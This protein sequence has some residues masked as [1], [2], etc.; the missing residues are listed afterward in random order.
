MNPQ[1]ELIT[2]IRSWYR[3]DQYQ[4]FKVADMREL[5]GWGKVETAELEAA[6][7]DLENRGEMVFL[8][9]RGWFATSREGWFVGTLSIARRGF[10]FVRALAVD[11]RGDVFIPIRRLR[12]GHHGDRVLVA[13]EKTRKGNPPLAGEGRSGKILEVI[14]RSPR[15][16][17]GY[18]Y[19]AEGGAGVV[20]P[21]RH[22]S[23]REVWIDPSFRSGVEDGDRVLAR[24]RSGAAI[25]GLPPGEVL[26]NWAPEG[27]WLA[28][29]Q[30]VCAEH[31]LREEFPAEVE[32]LAAAF[33][34]Q[35]SAE[36]LETRV[37]RR[38]LP[39]MTIDPVD[40][41]DFDDAIYALE[42]PE[43]GFRLG[44]A[45][46]DVSHFVSQ[47]DPI[48]QEALLRGTSVYIPGKTIPMLPERL[49]NGLCS[50]RPQEDRLAKIA[51]M[52][53]D[54]KGNFTDIQLEKSVIRSAHR[55]T[56]EGA[57]A[58]LEGNSTEEVSGVLKEQ[59]QVLN[60]LREILLKRRLRQG[61]LQ[62]EIEEMKLV[63]DDEGEVIDVISREHL[64]AHGLV[65]ECMLAANEAV[66]TFASQHQLPIL[67]RVHAPPDE[68][69]LDKFIKLCRVLV[70]EA[71][72]NSV[73]DL[74]KLIEVVTGSDLA[75]VV[76]FALLRSLTRA[77]YSPAKEVHFALQKQEYCHFTSPIRR[78]P[79]LQVHQILDRFF[80]TGG[81]GPKLSHEDVS[82]HELAENCST[83]ERA[84]E[85]AERDMSRLRAISW[86]RHRVGERFPGIVTSVRDQGFHVRLDGVLV[87]GFVHV[88][89]LRDDHYVF[90]ETHFALRGVNKGNMIRLGDPVEVELEGVD[91]LQRD[92]D[93]RYL[94]TRPGARRGRGTGGHAEPKGARSSKASKPRSQKSK[95]GGK[96]SAGRSRRRD[97][98]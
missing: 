18:F 45:I 69:E 20:E 34:E 5:P 22:E 56:Y 6:L 14:E 39:F 57:Q 28:D 80:S 19:E 8:F 33:P 63:L 60:Q 35:I 30:I 78:Y 61:A 76:F 71:P 54:S 44:V 68:S 64:E 11:P 3:S 37:D 2:A 87:D 50:L 42:L 36:E 55:F 24:L 81:E 75:P 65:E 82:L 9:A 26:C 16:F 21:A 86:L 92:I 73:D 70:S 62:L 13:L 53:L 31:E 46:A 90:N 94:H 85:A 89:R 25:D 91:P 74:P 48:D 32:E 72:V 77:E 12:D 97:R 47:G 51:W 17:P 66:A 10:G 1:S 41:K 84:A 88:S 23:V 79:D 27:T 98:R 95:R 40:A 96:N 29:L 59:V 93:L 38:E 49:S 43:G 7:S 58:I 83:R 4:P 15:V 67:R 52:D